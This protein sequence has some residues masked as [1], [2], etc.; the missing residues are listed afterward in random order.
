MEHM[1]AGGILEAFAAVALATIVLGVL[2]ATLEYLR[3]HRWPLWLLGGIVGPMVYVT[4]AGL[5][6]YVWDHVGLIVMC[7]FVASPVAM[8]VVTELEAHVRRRRA[9]ASRNR[10]KARR[11][12][13]LAGAITPSSSAARRVARSTS[14]KASASLSG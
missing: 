12:A 14:M 8:A 11:E 2:S 4:H 9:K 1:V 10:A 3:D 5:W 13:A 6:G 7:L